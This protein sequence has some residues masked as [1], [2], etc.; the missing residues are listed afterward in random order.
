MPTVAELTARAFSYWRPPPRLRLS[1]WADRHFYLSPESA[2]DPGKWHTLPYQRGIMDAITDP[3]VEQ[4]SVKKSSRVGYTKIINAAVGYYVHQDPCPIL[5]VQPT[6]SDAEE[7]SKEE[8]GPMIRDC[9][10]LTEL[11]AEPR[12]KDSNNTLTHKVFPGGILSLVGAN[13]PRGFRRV[14]RKVV[15][16]DEVDGYPPSAGAEGDQIK[17]GKRRA[18]YYWDRKFILG[19]TPTT[20]ALSRIS[21][22][23]AEGDQ[24]RY[25]VPCPHC[26]HRDY[27]VF[28]ERNDDRGHFMRW[29]KGNPEAA[30]FVCRECGG[31]IEEKHKRWMIER[32]DWRAHAP[33]K[34]HASF[35]IWAAYSYSPNATWGQIAAE[36]V[37]ASKGTPDELKTFVNTVLGEE[38]KDTGD[39]PDWEL[40]YA[41]REKYPI[42]TVPRGGLFLTAGVDVQK[43]RLEWEVWA[44]GRGKES[45][46]VEYGIEPGDTSGPD[47]WAK[48][49]ALLQRRFPTE[50]GGE[51]PVSILAV[52]SGFNTQTVYNW[53]RRYPLSRVIAIKGGT[54]A[55]L[56]VGP[57]SPVDVT[58]RGKRLKRGYRVWPI[59][60]GVAKSEFYGWLRLKPIKD[61][62]GNVTGYP[63]GFVHFPEYGE[64]YFQQITSETLVP[65]KERAGFTRLVWELPPGRR[66]E[67]LDCRVY[68]RAAAAVFGL[69]RLRES[70]WQAL[71]REA[72]NAAPT[73]PAPVAQADP[74][75]SAAP[76]PHPAQPSRPRKQPRAGKSWIGRRPGG[77][78]NRR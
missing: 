58:W 52:D 31:V 16:F 75:P 55:T 65:H 73:R 38:W 13:S 57:P 78:L 46:S 12:A 44:W 7:Y 59:G 3:E 53:A 2:A 30:H 27:L 76:A 51:L 33:F 4:V 63:P 19:S 69:D 8:I 39:A 60:S 11:I 35:H 37:A 40:L 5:V 29:P 14:S 1:E 36:F 62:A 42:G 15:I 10:V 28:N 66:N 72:G 18:E 50:A 54:S 21:K 56:L 22:I 49:D 45:W 61:E 67:R 77:W 9:P 17:L 64:D 70:D 34:G 23:Y 20:A 74:A 24:R 68:A 25:Y 43:D 71:E 47:V 41:R 48:I 32:G 26:R 6:E